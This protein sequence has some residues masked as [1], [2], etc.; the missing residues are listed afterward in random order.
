MNEMFRGFDFILAYNDDL[1]IITNVDW[2]DHLE[3]LEL[4]LQKLK[5][6][7]LKCNIKKSFL[8]KQKWN[9]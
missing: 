7:R 5:Y 2:S 4:T 6:N 8:D 3:K 1:L 9:I